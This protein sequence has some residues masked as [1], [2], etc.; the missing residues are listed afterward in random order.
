MRIE[1]LTFSVQDFNQK[2]HS[3]FSKR[4]TEVNAFK[5]VIG[6]FESVTV[7]D[8][9]E[10]SNCGKNPIWSYHNGEFQLKGVDENR[11]LYAMEECEFS[12]VK[13]YEIKLEVTSGEVVFSDSLF[14][15]F[16]ELKHRSINSFEGMIDASRAYEKIG[17]VYAPGVHFS[18]TVFI[19]EATNEIIIGSKGYDE[20]TDEERF[21]EHLTEAGQITTD[22]W[23]YSFTD[24]G[25]FKELGGVLDSYIHTMRVPNGTYV[26]TH[27]PLDP[28]GD[29]SEFIIIGQAKLTT[30]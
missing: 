1:Q 24:A 9:F 29:M 3:F 2:K 10:C 18:P 23:A 20:D 13:S 17:L 19:D 6:D 26:F 22:L 12:K 4:A 14:K 15:F 8:S 11:K 27:T 21:P 25:K 16:P 7:L 30:E 28:D 5:S